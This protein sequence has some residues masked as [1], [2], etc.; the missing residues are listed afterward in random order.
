MLAADSVRHDPRYLHHAL[1][2]GRFDSLVVRALHHRYLRSTPADWLRDLNLVAAAPQ[3]FDGFAPE[4]VPAGD[5]LPPCPACADPESGAEAHAEIRLLL[6]SVWR[7]SAPSAAPPSGHA[8]RRAVLGRA[9]LEA[10]CADYGRRPRPDQATTRTST[11]SLP[12]AG[13]TRW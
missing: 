2:L 12:T 8:D 1:A 6:A 9:S 5:E 10:L 13:S 11:P 7:L 3:A 4:H